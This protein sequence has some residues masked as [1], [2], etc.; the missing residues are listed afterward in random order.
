MLFGRADFAGGKHP[1]ELCHALWGWNE[2]GRIVRSCVLH[3]NPSPRAQAGQDALLPTRHN[4]RH[5]FPRPFP[6]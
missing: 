2:R 3:C 1:S 5:D 4:G 6:A